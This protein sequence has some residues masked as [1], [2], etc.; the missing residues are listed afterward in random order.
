MI[1]TLNHRPAT[2]DVDAVFERDRTFVRSAAGLIAEE[3]GWPAEWLNDSV[4]GF[5]QPC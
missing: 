5:S 4:N 3:F 1:L 2:R